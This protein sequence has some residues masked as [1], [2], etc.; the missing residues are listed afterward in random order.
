M[1]LSNREQ[2]GWKQPPEWNKFE[3][4][5]EKEYGSTT[6]YCGI[7]LE[8]AWREYH[9]RHRLE[10]IINDLIDAAGWP[11]QSNGE[12]NS[13]RSRP[14]TSDT[15]G[16]V[17]ICVDQDVK[18]DM[19]A[20]AAEINSPKHEVL[21]AVVNWYLEGGLVGKATEKLE[22]VIDDVVSS[23]ESCDDDR[24]LGAVQRRTRTLCR[25]LTSDTAEFAR[26]DL[27]TALN[28]SEVKG[29]SN[30]EHTRE[31][32]LPKVLDRIDYQP[33]PNN[34]DLFLPAE[35][36]KTL[37]KNTGF[38][39]NGPKIDHW[40]P[41]DLDEDELIHG[42][43]VKLVREAIVGTDFTE[44]TTA[45]IE[46]DVLDGR[47]SSQKIVSVMESVAVAN[48]FKIKNSDGKKIAVN[49]QHI[50]DSMILKDAKAA[51]ERARSDCDDRINGDSQ[52]EKSDGENS[53]TSD[54][55]MDAIM[56]STP[57]TNGNKGR[58]SD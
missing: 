16:R 14:V 2:L 23:L 15:D 48:G 29:I 53:V 43:R 31:K 18:T 54:E 25:L 36:V 35:R 49:L 33:H 44:F 47:L 6:P 51:T 38:V 40:A 12:K 34:P 8:D 11:Q 21:R 41:E 3:T 5:V 58:E 45:N 24:S 26:D 52:N 37:A 10:D 30:S 7:V 27:N 32:Y 19:E 42:V 28:S 22:L 4:A 46:R 56:S 1:R 9:T 39:L 20:Y 55:Q 13:L 57:V 50:D 17:W